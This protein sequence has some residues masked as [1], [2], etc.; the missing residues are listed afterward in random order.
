MTLSLKQCV[1]ILNSM[2]LLTV[3][4]VLTCSLVPRFTTNRTVLSASQRCDKWIYLAC[5]KAVPFDSGSQREDLVPLLKRDQDQ[6][7][8]DTDRSFARFVGGCPV[9]AGEERKSRQNNLNTILNSVFSENG[10]LSYTQGFMNVA[11]TAYEVCD[12]MERST[13]LVDCMAKTQFFRECLSSGSP[14][15]FK[16]IPVFSS[17]FRK[18]EVNKQLVRRLD[19][20]GL[21]VYIAHFFVVDGMTTY[22]ARSIKSLEVVTRLYDFFLGSRETHMPLYTSIAILQ[23]IRRK[24]FSGGDISAGGINERLQTAVS[25]LNMNDIDAIIKKSKILLKDHPFNTLLNSQ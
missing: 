19:K 20:K 1:S 11:E 23:Q 8:G 16:L 6:I 9:Y 13:R 7:K 12:D 4:V 2:C 10:D 21:I 17:L 14:E 25:K 15:I 3:I 22:F 5:D 18:S 24:V